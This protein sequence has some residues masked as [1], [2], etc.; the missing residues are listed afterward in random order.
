LTAT[1]WGADLQTTLTLSETT[2]RASGGKGFRAPSLHETTFRGAIKRSGMNPFLYE[3]ANIS[4]QDIGI[5]A[6]SYSGKR[7]AAFYRYY[8]TVVNIEGTSYRAI[9]IHSSAHDK[10]RN[11]RIDRSLKSSKSELDKKIKET[12]HQPFKCLPDAEAPG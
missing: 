2:V 4:I 5:M 3:H 1:V 9:V 6:E 11:K 8:D 12:I 7:P 10:R